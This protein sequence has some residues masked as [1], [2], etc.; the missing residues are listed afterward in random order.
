MRGK[1]CLF[2]LACAAAG[3]A[4]GR[5]AS[6]RTAI[7]LLL[8]AAGV[9]ALFTG[10]VKSRRHLAVPAAAAC[11]WM[12]LSMA[13]FGGARSG[14][15]PRLASSTRVVT[16]Y[17]R[18]V[19]PLSTK[20]DSSAFFL[21]VSSMEEGRGGRAAGERVL[22]RA[23]GALPGDEYYPGV[24]VR[25]RGKLRPPGADAS[26][27]LERGAA[28]SLSVSGGGISLSRDP[29]DAISRVVHATRSWVSGRY[30]MLFDRRT[31][32]LLQGVTLSKLDLLDS[33]TR[34]DLK[35]CGLS[36]IVAV[37]GLHVG[38]AATLVL[39]LGTA[40]G[41]RRSGRYALAAL[42]AFAVLAVSGF[43]PSATRAAVMAAAGYGGALAGR[44]Y[45]PL[46][47]ISIAG[48]G[49]LAAN[50]RALFDMGFQYSFAAAGGIII[51]A[52]WVRDRRK[53][54]APAER[55]S[56]ARTFLAACAGAQLGILPLMLARGEGVPVA[57]VLANLLV[58]P[59]VGPMLLSG[60]SSAAMS[61]ISTALARAVAVLPGALAGYVMAVSSTL[62]KVPPA[63][64]RGTAL[65]ALSLL[66]YVAGLVLA[67]RAS[68]GG[69]SLLMPGIAIAL[70]MA[71]ALF[72]CAALQPFGGRDT[73]TF[74]DVG[75]GDAILARDSKGACVLVD[76][77]PD[78][79]LLMEKLEKRGVRKID[80]AVST[81]PHAD[82]AAGLVEAIGRT[83][84]GV[85][86]EP[87]EPRDSALY[88][89]L[90]DVARDGGV[91]RMTA[92]E[93]QVIKV[94]NATSLE[95]LRAPMD[96]ER[97]PGDA[98]DCSLVLVLSMRGMR[99]LLSADAGARAQEEIVAGRPWLRCEVLKVSHQGAREATSEEL[100]DT[101]RPV[102]A[103]ISVGRDN[104]Y[105]HPSPRCLELLSGR[106]IRIT[107][108]DRDGDVEVS[109]SNGRIGLATGGR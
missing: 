32:G 33:G 25:A 108:T 80:L 22:V 10:G 91:E 37:S 85:L 43:R 104:D 98:N 17:G 49:M 66:L 60:W 36:H 101:C 100:L 107:R 19:S 21:A 30:A 97:L 46:V 47:G 74:L 23:R 16:L 11:V 51:S 44:R 75:E 81:H 18:I 1:R 53:E 105:G 26:W 40:A 6:S 70:A 103:V 12:M 102:L 109:V 42:S 54:R 28:C 95:V 93:G 45:D 79:G 13:Q 56:G 15:L 68:G 106:G 14:V 77:G 61:L 88:R 62:A 57:A 92:R 7:A 73:V 34:S 55:A 76:G 20:G 31:A 71:L 63:G 87:G 4:A 89:K 29:P 96:L 72:S 48:L 67:L 69:T 2:C 52:R 50:P 35:R 8:C 99:V 24:K 27:M 64:A 86:L 9:A 3:T 90:V 5:Y 82:H 78:P 94:S 41:V 58:V 39:A 83:P 84:T 38:A 59:A 65:A